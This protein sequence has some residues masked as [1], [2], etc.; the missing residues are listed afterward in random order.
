MEESDCRFSDSDDDDTNNDGSKSTS[1]KVDKDSFNSGTDPFAGLLKFKSGRN[2]SSGLWYVDYSKLT[3]MDS[4]ER[5]KLSG[6]LLRTKEEIERLNATLKRTHEHR[7]RLLS[8]PTNDHLVSLLAESEMV[9]AELQTQAENFR[10][11]MVNENDKKDIKKNIARM[12]KWWRERR[13]L[14]VEFL[15]GLEENT[16]GQVTLKKCLAGD[17]PIVLDSDE[18]V[19]KAAVA[20]V[21]EKRIRRVNFACAQGSQKRRKHGAD[22]KIH[23]KI[24][25]SLADENFAAVLL[26]SQGS[27]ER[28]YANDE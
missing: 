26:N 10:K 13:K 24:D 11:L 2:T 5:Q 9:T 20:S 14:V 17:G 18:T 16:D 15:V 3:E 23:E 27:V 8:E 22:E 28:V 4:D 21:R 1:K 7:E 19:A 6:D 25:I 12:T